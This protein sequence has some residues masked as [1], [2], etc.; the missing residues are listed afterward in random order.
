VPED[1]ASPRSRLIALPVVRIRSR[2]AHPL[3]LASSADLLSPSSIRAES[4]AYAACAR[5]LRRGGVDL[6]GYTDPEMADDI[7]AARV[8]F[9]YKRIDLLGE[10]AGT[11]LAEIYMWRYPKNVDRS[12]LIGVNPP[13]NFVYN[14]A[15]LDQQLE[16]Y[17][18]LCEQDPACRPSSRT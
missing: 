12:V 2:S 10:S 6:G 4:Q 11:R 9:G 18:T 17:S 1:R 3:A 16:Q 13:G 14:G 5:R 7:E 8:A 15:I